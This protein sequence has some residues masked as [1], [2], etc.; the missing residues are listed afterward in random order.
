MNT[1]PA[2]ADATAADLGSDSQAPLPAPV[3]ESAPE[4]AR[5]LLH[6]PVDVRSL[7][8][9]VL[10]VLACLFALQLDRKSVV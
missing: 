2:P 1:A 8:L 3:P 9:A 7:S 6:M 5:L 10:A 4:P